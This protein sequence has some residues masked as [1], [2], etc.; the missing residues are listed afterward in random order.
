MLPDGKDK[1]KFVELSEEDAKTIQR[2]PDLNAEFA[3]YQIKE[4]PDS[5]SFYKGNKPVLSYQKHDDGKGW[6]VNLHHGDRKDDLGLLQKV[7][8]PWQF[9]EEQLQQMKDLV[10]GG[11]KDQHRYDIR[12]IYDV[13]YAQIHGRAAKLPTDSG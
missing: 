3:P 1:Q 10:A 8:G 2:L 12:R 5:L 13:R 4:S 11:K 7:L 6:T 9:S